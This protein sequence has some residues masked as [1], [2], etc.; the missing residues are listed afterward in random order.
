MVFKKKFKRFFGV[1]GVVL[2]GALLLNY[3]DITLFL[4]DIYQCWFWIFYI[5]NRFLLQLSK[6]GPKCKARVRL[7]QEEVLLAL[8][9]RAFLN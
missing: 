9:L 8:R 3:Y 4:F 5:F 1:R 2:T 7:L 6:E